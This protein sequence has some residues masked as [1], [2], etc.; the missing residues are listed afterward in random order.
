VIHDQGY[1]IGPQHKPFQKTI[2]D[3]REQGRITIPKQRKEHR[4]KDPHPKLVEG[5]TDKL[6]IDV[7]GRANAGSFL[8][9]LAYDKNKWSGE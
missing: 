9:H 1:V 5:P 6:N 7:P 2:Y 4:K 3:E 8:N